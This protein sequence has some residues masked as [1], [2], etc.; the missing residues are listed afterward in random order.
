MLPNRFSIDH[1]DPFVSLALPT[2]EQE[3]RA[4]EHK[5]MEACEAWYEGETCLLSSLR[6]PVVREVVREVL[7]E[8]D[9][10]NV[11]LRPHLRPQGQGHTYGSWGT[12]AITIPSRTP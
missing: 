7:W 11:T 6:T 12:T 8:F 3:Q 10:V 4:T 2:P 5:L 9:P 1:T